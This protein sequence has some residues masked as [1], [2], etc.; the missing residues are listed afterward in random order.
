METPQE[1]ILHCHACSRYI[2]LEDGKNEG[3]IVVCPF[4]K[5]ENVIATMTVFIGK[6]RDEG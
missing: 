2:Q 4:C 5:T 1:R 6:P 3:D